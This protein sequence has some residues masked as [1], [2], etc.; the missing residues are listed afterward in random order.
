MHKIYQVFQEIGIIQPLKTPTAIYTMEHSEELDST[1]LFNGQP[2]WRHPGEMKEAEYKIKP[3]IVI[4]DIKTIYLYSSVYRNDVM[5]M[6][7]VLDLMN[8]KFL[9]RCGKE[10]FIETSLDKL[11]YH[12]LDF[13]YAEHDEL[14]NELITSG[15]D[16]NEFFIF[17]HKVLSKILSLVNLEIFDFI[18]APK[19][20]ANDKQINSLVNW[21]MQSKLPI[22]YAAAI[23]DIG[24]KTNEDS[25]DD[26]LFYIRITWKNHFTRNELKILITEL[27]SGKFSSFIASEH[28]D[29]VFIADY[30]NYAMRIPE[31]PKS[32]KLKAEIDVSKFVYLKKLCAINCTP[33]GL[34]ELK[35]LNEVKIYYPKKALMNELL[36]LE[37][38]KTKVLLIED[39]GY[40]LN[41]EKIPPNIKN[42]V[43]GFKDNN[44]ARTYSMNSRGEMVEVYMSTHKLVKQ[45]ERDTVI[46]FT[47]KTF[48][49]LIEKAIH[50]YL[51]FK[52]NRIA[53]TCERMTVKFIKADFATMI[54]LTNFTKLKKICLTSKH[55]RVI[56][57]QK[58]MNVEELQL[59]GINGNGLDLRENINLKKL[60]IKNSS[61]SYLLLPTSLEALELLQTDIKDFSIVGL[62]RLMKITFSKQGA[63]DPDAATYSYSVQG[64]KGGIPLYGYMSLVSII[65]HTSTTPFNLNI[66][67]PK[68]YPSNFNLDEDYPNV[69]A[70]AFITDMFLN[71]KGKNTK[72]KSLD[73]NTYTDPNK[74]VKLTKIFLS[75]KISLSKCRGHINDL[76]KFD[77]E[78]GICL[79][80]SKVISIP[81][82]PVFAQGGEKASE[83]IHLAKGKIYTLTGL[84]ANDQLC[85][86]SDIEN[87]NV[88]KNNFQQYQ[89][90]L[91]PDG[92][93]HDSKVIE[94]EIAADKNYFHAVNIMPNIIPGS[95]QI[96]VDQKL[97][98]LL[99]ELVNPV[100]LLKT[101]GLS[102]NQILQEII[103]YCRWEEGNKEIENDNNQTNSD[104]EQYRNMLKDMIVNKKGACRHRSIVA[105][106]FCDYFQIP[107]RIVENA[108]NP[109]SLI[110]Q[111]IE[112]CTLEGKWVGVDLGGHAVEIE[113][114]E[115]PKAN[116]QSE[117]LTIETNNEYTELFLRKSEWM[118]Q[119]TTFGEFFDKIKDNRHHFLLRTNQA[120]DERQYY[121]AFAE[122]LGKRQQPFLYID[123]A[124]DLNQLLN[125][126]EI[127]T[128]AF[129]RIEGP[130]AEMIRR[131]EGTLLINWSNFSDRER[132]IY[133]SLIDNPPNLNGQP[134]SKNIRVI[135]MM[136]NNINANDV[137]LSRCHAL[138][139][140]PSLFNAPEKMQV[141][142]LEPAAIQHQLYGASDWARTLLYDT[143]FTN[144]LPTIR[145]GI[146]QEAMEKG[147]ALEI[148]NPPLNDPFFDLCLMRLQVE[149]KLL[150]NGK[151]VIAKPGFKVSLKEE[152]I[153][154]AQPTLLAQLPVNTQGKQ[155]FIS[156]ATFP[157]LFRMNSFSPELN[158]L[159][160]LLQ[161][162]ENGDQ[163]ILTE[164]FTSAELARLS[165]FIKTLPADKQNIEFYQINAQT[166]IEKPVIHNLDDVLTAKQNLHIEAND[167]NFLV[168]LLQTEGGIPAE[169][170]CYLTG[171]NALVQ[172]IE[173][174]QLSLTD[175]E[176]VSKRQP[177][178]I[179][180]KLN[181]GETIIIQG[182]LTYEE[183]SILQSLFANPP[184]LVVNGRRCDV[185]GRLYWVSKPQEKHT[186]F[187]KSHVHFNCKLE[188]Y[189]KILRNHLS[190]SIYI[191][192][193][194]A[195]VDSAINEE[196]VK[197]LNTFFNALQQ[198]PSKQG[199]FQFTYEKYYQFYLH[200]L[201]NDNHKNPLKPFLSYHFAKNSVEY[202]Y[203][204][205]I[206]KL[207]FDDSG[208]YVRPE[209]LLAM[210]SRYFDEENDKFKTDNDD[211]ALWKII[212]CF[213]GEFMRQKFDIDLN[214]LIFAQNAIPSLSPEVK[215]RI[216]G[217]L[218]F[219]LDP[220]KS[221]RIAR[222]KKQNLRLEAAINH[223]THPITYLLGEAGTG[224]T[225]SVRKYANNHPN[226]D[227]HEG[228]DQDTI[229]QWL[230]AQDEN[231]DD[232]H[233]LLLDE[234]NLIK[235]GG[236]EFLRGL[237]Q[238]PA[239]IYFN[240]KP[241]PVSP[242]HKV[243]VTGNPLSYR[244]RHFHDALWD[245]ANVIWYGIP[246]KSTIINLV[247][248]AF[249]TASATI[250]DQDKTAVS[251]FLADLYHTML[252]D[253][254]K[255]DGITL[256]DI[257]NIV[258][259]L[260]LYKKQSS[261]QSWLNCAKLSAY[262]EW[263][264][265]YINPKARDEFRL[266]LNLPITMNA[267]PFIT[268]EGH[269]VTA[270]NVSVWRL[271]LAH[272]ALDSTET[273][274][275]RGIVLEGS[276]GIGKS[277]IIR[278]ALLEAGYRENHNNSQKRFY[279]INAG[280][281][282]AKEILE[283][284]DLL[285][286]KVF[287]DELNLDPDAE[288]Y[289]NTL[290]DPNNTIPKCDIILAENRNEFFN[291]PTKSKVSYVI[292]DQELFY[293]NKLSKECIK[294]PIN[295][296][297]V[298]KLMN[299]IKPTEDAK[300]LTH[301]QIKK[302][303]TFTGHTPTK[304]SGFK[305]F[306]A[307]NPSYYQGC[308]KVGGG[309]E[310]RFHKV[311]M[312][313][314]DSAGLEYIAK[315]FNHPNP[316]RF[317]MGFFK[318]KA[319][320]PGQVNTRTFFEVL[321]ERKMI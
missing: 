103:A 28:L 133:K 104:V 36:A 182:N 157:Q 21:Y 158:T 229:L 19:L 288:E 247:N 240:Q 115:A 37:G 43:K 211:E 234:G 42:F 309:L 152:P 65:D 189:E 137:F 112:I 147:I 87:L 204:N 273:G 193:K 220:F 110:H 99:T 215:E 144:G 27:M 136:N 284:A 11:A 200:L 70:P 163:F 83:K 249:V 93:N 117:N 20:A 34:T 275:K 253:A 295:A 243:I 235:R 139:L 159:S 313:D 4:N 289:L 101:T 251:T 203:A 216:Y 260:M 261:T 102:R 239:V 71:Y 105:K 214:Q 248:Q 316:A 64:V 56:G 114:D 250:N 52:I 54:D 188:D 72:V 96:A 80:K 131:G 132:A 3:V 302:I 98:A 180:E 317:V 120:A 151:L 198:L 283:E 135:G 224:K 1:L 15:K 262:D 6:F 58:C 311:M 269:V 170:I 5:M 206:A 236:L 7:R 282:N 168:K 212:N 286:S 293:M 196:L 155:Y 89:I 202:A 187:S 25:D 298:K 31:Y 222:E 192:H 256:R 312:Q 32:Y 119:L 259:R 69:R 185:P 22:I 121:A 307:R 55:L 176:L 221:K 12:A 276:S 167:P 207:L 205:S 223:Q 14:F 134:L 29:E 130:L 294:I 33:S 95:F 138:T 81:V 191:S 272:L 141:E 23:T 79:E 125:P 238:N 303:H 26:D 156:R 258:A 263:H 186:L 35:H 165:A 279:H 245:H 57:L 41:L 50:Q 183:Q 44:L 218:R 162:S 116:E 266:K 254:N 280:S 124:A 217:Y 118:N 24:A 46:P 274:A 179:W 175:K 78:E 270:N 126:V 197:K 287:L 297:N 320:H 149:G 244:G 61:L 296:A 306:S 190:P 319:D 40:A 111:Y 241:Y 237:T 194:R 48:Q 314:Y 140:P 209:Q 8:C 97:M 177:S 277:T 150:I 255:T 63:Y 90:E 84:S 230:T 9:L 173:K 271:L 82:Q 10:K 210:K 161:N 51:N 128:N 292:C 164:E 13:E 160:G 231:E 68:Y 73:F 265:L 225:S 17:D 18:L 310:S 227:L 127:T 143:T 86:L 49:K 91:K 145:T 169:N 301:K 154:V 201:N 74:K 199:Y 291:L 174:V 109:K 39:V 219:E 267:S 94:Y 233:L 77:D 304:K 321:A 208:E 246:D 38:E 181:N 45:V 290:L 53:T 92:P 88:Y 195:H 308:E 122:E 47:E 16:P 76:I 264:G 232:I 171:Q 228:S 153:Q 268:K 107:A 100:Q 66:S 67:R 148:I 242:R 59:K 75:E 146:F 129:K 299:S 108:N 85:Y 166:Q 257:E 62:D 30:A 106:M 305:V 178:T 226:I 2:F 113:F 315:V 285:G 60:T 252:N 142:K 213:S 278:D 300:T 318:A 123:N 184:Y 281:R 172:L